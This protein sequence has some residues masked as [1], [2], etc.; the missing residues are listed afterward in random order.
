MNL[1][2][3]TLTFSP[4]GV[5][6]ERLDLRHVK[7]EASTFSELVDSS[8]KLPQS[9]EIFIVFCTISPKEGFEKVKEKLKTSKRHFRIL[10]EGESSFLFETVKDGD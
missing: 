10:K 8:Q 9:I 2:K 4:D 1:G 3:R 5:N 6:I 7:L